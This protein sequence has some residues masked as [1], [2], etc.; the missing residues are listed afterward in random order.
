MTTRKI[1]VRAQRR[2][3]G[4]GHPGREPWS[5]IMPSLRSLP[6]LEHCGRSCNTAAALQKPPEFSRSLE[7]PEKPPVLSIFPGQQLL[8]VPA[9]HSSVPA[10]SLI[11]IQGNTILPLT[12]VRQK[13]SHTNICSYK[14]SNLAVKIEVGSLHFLASQSKIITLQ[15]H[16]TKCFPH[17]YLKR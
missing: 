8:A 4:P 14:M 9:Q 2:E 7:V 12:Q 16:L 3:Q 5:Y 13:V 15:Q 6:R 1:T 17:F 11:S 10:F